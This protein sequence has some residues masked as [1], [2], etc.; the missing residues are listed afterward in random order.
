MISIKK[1]ILISLILGSFIVFVGIFTQSNVLFGAEVGGSDISGSLSCGNETAGVSVDNFQ[2]IYDPG[3]PSSGVGGLGGAPTCPDG[4]LQ[5][6]TVYC[7]ENACITSYSA[8]PV[9]V[10]SAPTGTLTA[11]G[12]SSSSVGGTCNASISWTTSSSVLNATTFS[13]VNVYDVSSI[14]SNPPPY[15]GAWTSGVSFFSE[16]TANGSKTVSL[17]KGSYLFSLYGSNNG[18]TATPNYVKLADKFITVSDPT[19]LPDLGAGGV[20]WTAPSVPVTSLWGQNIV[21]N[22][23]AVNSTA[24]T[25]YNSG[26]MDVANPISVIT[27]LD[28]N[29]D[30]VPESFQTSTMPTPSATPSMPSQSWANGTW[31]SWVLP[32][33]ANHMRVCVDMTSPSGGG[34]VAESN[35]NNNCGPWVPFTVSCAAGYHAVGSS[36]CALGS[37]AQGLLIVNPCTVPIGSTTCTA[38][39][40]SWSATGVSNAYIELSGGSYGTHPTGTVPSWG[41]ALSG[42]NHTFT[43]S[44]GNFDMYMYGDYTKLPLARIPSSIASG[45]GEPTG[46][47]AD[48]SSVFSAILA[49]N[50]SQIL[51]TQSGD[52]TLLAH[53]SI[54]IDTAPGAVCPWTGQQCTATT[55]N[56][57]GMN[58]GVY[59]DTGTNL[60]Q[61]SCAC[62][63]A[64]SDCPKPNSH[65][66]S[67]PSI[68]NKGGTCS[69]TWGATTPGSHMSCTLVG[70]NVSAACSQSGSTKCAPDITTVTP[71]LNA[72]TNY[73]LTCQNGSTAAQTVQI[74]KCTINPVI[75][76]R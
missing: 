31:N 20:W 21:Y 40:V 59:V 8:C 46:L 74:A 65:V 18:S 69:L 42:S 71:A 52:G 61:G 75:Q 55:P 72:S 35:E 17:P 73:T 9:S 60:G 2:G 3:N 49:G 22:A 50:P 6:S 15:T 23:A 43:V 41:N 26:P 13:Q 76:E 68:I 38:S 44:A 33:G 36:G 54:T 37:L 47:L 56:A 1:K 16:T 24:A 62:T 12:C 66:I 14:T 27:E 34:T 45:Y 29:G 53:Q 11:T 70:N 64:D 57:C 48:L 39:V 4:S 10:G 51:A 25:G 5:P 30:G 58:V 32:T 28:T 63:I 67:S 7:T 19:D